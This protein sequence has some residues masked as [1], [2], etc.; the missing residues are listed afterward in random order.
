M[1]ALCNM[2]RSAPICLRWLL[3]LFAFLGGGMVAQAESLRVMTY[4]IWVGGRAGG[5]PLADTAAVIA[6]ANPDIV[7]L[8]EQSGAARQL[9][10]IL[11]MNVHVTN[12]DIAYLT[13]FPI[14]GTSADGIRVR[15]GL[16]SHANVFNIHYAA[17]PYGPYDLRDDPS[18]TEASLV[19][20][21]VATRG[22]ATTNT[23]AAMQIAL[24]SGEP[25]FLLGDFNEPSHLDWTNEAADA[26]L[27]FGATVAWPT[28]QSIVDAGLTDSFRAV[29]PDEVSR[30]AET[31]TPGYP[32]PNLSAD[33]VH[34]RIDLIYHAGDGVAALQAEVV[35]E[36]LAHADIV[37]AP[38]PSDHRAVVV[39]FE[40]PTAGPLP[41]LGD[42]NLDGAVNAA[43]ASLIQQH[44]LQRFDEGN[45]I[46]YQAGDL[47]RDG[48]VDLFD[49]NLF[50]TGLVTYN[51]TTGGVTV[52]EPA[53]WSVMLM[54]WLTVCVA[55]GVRRRRHVIWN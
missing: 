29:W 2:F 48:V 24:E 13:R 7:G 27:H 28:S 51:N 46:S 34:D 17:Y 47:N 37:V 55:R 50:Q 10:E 43:D 8:Q 41:L 4:N 11:E 20:T 1:S 52:P 6:A 31:W 18:L 49:V 14:E 39:T 32:A 25:T 21:A 45:V 38:Y 26:G 36:S 54:A 15:T 33:E 35:G 5:Y 30:P 12:N 53:G 3:L 22:A 44:W 9:A 23:L 16:D 40:V 42:V 19:A